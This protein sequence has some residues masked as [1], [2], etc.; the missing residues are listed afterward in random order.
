MARAAG[1]HGL[2]RGDARSTRAHIGVIGRGPGTGPQ[3]DFRGT[4][5]AS[6]GPLSGVENRRQS[7][8]LEQMPGTTTVAGPKPVNH[9]EPLFKERR[10]SAFHIPI[11]LDGERRRR[12][13]VGQKVVDVPVG[14][15]LGCAQMMFE[16][17]GD[18]SASRPVATAMSC[19]ISNR[20][21]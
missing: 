5:D 2:L 20:T 4:S 19:E 14:P 18:T 7:L 17:P 21:Q 3:N 8:T 10:Q 13:C 9:L 6:G 16:P 15:S 11:G 1:T 12:S